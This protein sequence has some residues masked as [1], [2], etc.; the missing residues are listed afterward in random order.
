MVMV[1]ETMRT[2][3][4]T[5]VLADGLYA[6]SLG[7]VKDIRG[8]TVPMPLEEVPAYVTGYLEHPLGHLPVLDLRHRLDL[9]AATAA[10]PAVHVVLQH[11]ELCFVLQ[12]DAV[13]EVVDLGIPYKPAGADEEGARGGLAW[14]RGAAPVG[15]RMALMLDLGQ[16][17]PPADRAAVAAAIASGVASGA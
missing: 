9:P 7:A 11:G 14:L 3:Y 2:Q 4:L 5:L 1:D 12:A 6:V 13:A 10:T 17:L 15:E 8:A 16:L